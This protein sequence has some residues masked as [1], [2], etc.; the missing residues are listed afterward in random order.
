MNR[1]S[2]ATLRRKEIAH[3]AA[4]LIVAVAAVVEAD[5]LVAAAVEGVPAAAVVVAA[6][7]AVVVPAV[8]AEAEADPDTK[9]E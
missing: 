8:V 4:A 6:A 2:T 1:T 9:L 5:A 3:Q 7:D